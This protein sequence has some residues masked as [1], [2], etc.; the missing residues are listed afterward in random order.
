MASK[1]EFL[2]HTAHCYPC[3]D[4]G[5]SHPGAKFTSCPEDTT[6]C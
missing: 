6:L 3:L 5:E 4:G 1:E 2:L